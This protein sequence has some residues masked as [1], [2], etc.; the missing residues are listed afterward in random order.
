MVNVNGVAYDTQAM[1]QYAILE[2]IGNSCDH[3]RVPSSPVR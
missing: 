1:A 2:W 3:L